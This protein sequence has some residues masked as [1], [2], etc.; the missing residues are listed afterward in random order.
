VTMTD[1][2]RVERHGSVLV[3]SLARPEKRNAIDADMVRQLD[4]GFAFAESSVDIRACVLRAEGP[5]FSAGTDLH[6]R[7]AAEIQTELGGEYGLVRRERTKPLIA[8]V[9]GA[10]LGGGFELVLACDIVVATSAAYFGFP[11]VRRGLI[12]SCGG[13]FRGPR[14]L[15][16]NIG[17]EL[18]IGGTELSAERAY[19]LGFVNRLEN[20][21]RA[22]ESAFEI[23]G[24]IAA[25]S[26]DAV[27]IAFRAAREGF[28]RE[29]ADE[30]VRNDVAVAEARSSPQ[31]VEGVKAFFDRRLPNWSASS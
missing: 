22:L 20:P 14:A 23:A 26:P 9:E 5:V 3:V 30:W 1:T 12:P 31:S 25:G 2:V 28:L 21:E 27:R 8:V 17:L 11:E 10:A 13:L 18:L 29:E 15:P 19:E 6:V 16:R 4:Q 24:N 7:S